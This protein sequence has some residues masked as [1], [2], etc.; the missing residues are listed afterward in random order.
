MRAI[1][2]SLSAALVLTGCADVPST[3]PGSG[4]IAHP[5]GTDDLILSVGWEGGFVPTEYLFTNA[6]SFALYGD[7]TLI[8]PGAQ[9][10][11][12][13][14]PALPPFVARTVSE[15]G[16]QAIL[17]RALEAGLDLDG[18][19]S[20]L[21]NMG[22]ADAGT[23]TFVLSA[24]GATHRVTA[25][26]LGMEGDERV[27]GQPEDVWSTRRRLSDFMSEIGTLDAWLPA[28]SLGDERTYEATSARLLVGPAT[29]DPDLP[30]EPATWPLEVP[31][32]DLG[33]AAPTLGEGWRCAVI[34]GEDWATVE[35]AARRANQLTPWTSHGGSYRL[36]FRP[37]LPDEAGCPTP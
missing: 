9:I 4:A 35:R 29:T 2:L 36:V 22:I 21:G 10:E 30:Q 37:L 34:D 18:D 19:Y 7:G 1:I 28:G 27:D 12:Y 14:G 8:T 32:R 24:D 11:L 13:P 16:I 15:E 23:A 25:Y 17:H 33:D 20:D 6:P 3:P 31:L 26:A 5:T